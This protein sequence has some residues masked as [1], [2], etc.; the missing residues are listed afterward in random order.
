[1]PEAHVEAPTEGSVLLAGVL[2]KLGSYGYLRFLFPLFPDGTYYYTPFVL[3]LGSLG[4]YYTSFVTLRQIDIKRVIAYSSIS[5]M[6]LCILGL[7]SFNMMGIL[8]S[9]HLMIGHGLVSSGL[10]FLVGMLYYRFHTKIIKYYSGLIYIMPLFS[11]FFFL[12]ILG[13][14]SFPL[15]SNFIGEFLILIGLCYSFNFY[16]LFFGFIG[17][18]ICTVYSI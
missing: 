2:L 6:N 7:F 17:I 10:F 3:F 16:S 11:F 5:H 1:L 15:T 14:I 4:I 8:G 9:I 18:F 12:F 13:N